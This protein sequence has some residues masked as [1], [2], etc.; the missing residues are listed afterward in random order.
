MVFFLL[1]GA[2]ALPFQGNVAWDD[3]RASE[4]CFFFSGPLELGRDDHLGTMA[5]VRRGPSTE[6]A[7][8]RELP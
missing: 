4:G 2:G 5:S 3:V 1:L 6:V 8:G 7:F